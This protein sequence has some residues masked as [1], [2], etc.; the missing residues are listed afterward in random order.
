[1]VIPHIVKSCGLNTEEAALRAA[2]EADAD[3]VWYP[4]ASVGCTAL[5]EDDAGDACMGMEAV[6][7]DSRERTRSNG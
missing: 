1:M 2:A 7:I 4:D 5:G 3:A 6:A